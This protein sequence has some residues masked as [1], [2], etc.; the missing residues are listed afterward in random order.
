MSSWPSHR[1]SSIR[2][3]ASTAAG[4]RAICAARSICPLPREHEL[5]RTA[6]GHDLLTV[7]W[8]WRSSFY[9]LRTWM[10]SHADRPTATAIDLADA[11]RACSAS[12]GKTFTCRRCSAITVLWTCAKRFKSSVAATMSAPH[13]ERSWSDSAWSSRIARTSVEHHR[14]CP[15]GAADAAAHPPYLRRPHR[16]QRCMHRRCEARSHHGW[17]DDRSTWQHL[18]AR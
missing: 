7:P 16:R 8:R 10:Q 4:P 13:H 3:P 15:G 6:P 1:R 17:P 12:A 18:R 2:C 11:R 9:L 14:P 5:A